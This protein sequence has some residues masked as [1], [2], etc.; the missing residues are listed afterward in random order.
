MSIKNKENPEMLGK[1]RIIALLGEGSMGVVYKAVDPDIQEY[2]AIKTIHKK[3]LEGKDRAVILQRFVNEVKAGRLLRHSNIVAIYHYE[4]VEDTCFLVMEYV[5]GTT[6][7]E[8]MQ[9]NPNLPK[10]EIC[11]IMD[12]LLDGLQ[13]AHKQGVIHRDIKPENLIL[14]DNGDVRIADFG[15]ARL[16]S[17]AM[18]TDGSILGSPAY[19]SP[20]QCRGEQVDARSDLF[21]AGVVLY[22]LLTGEKPFSGMAFMETMQQ[23]LNVDPDLPSTRI[24]TLEPKWDHV[25]NKALAKHADNRYQ[26]AT[27]F[28]QALRA[29]GDYQDIDKL[30]LKKNRWKMWLVSS[31]VMAVLVAGGFW[32][33]GLSEI[34]VKERKGSVA[35]VGLI[36]KPEPEITVSLDQQMKQLLINYE[37][38]ELFYT[39]DVKDNIISVTGFV[40]AINQN[41]LQDDLTGL[42][43][44]SNQS[45]ELK[46]SPLIDQNCTLLN[47]LKPFVQR[48]H[49]QKHGLVIEPSQHDSVFVEGERPVFEV[50][51]PD[52]PG[53]LYVDYY[54]A[55]GK[56]FHLLPNNTSQLK[57][58]ANQLIFIGK[59]GATR[60]WE[61]VKP[62][63]K[64]V[65]SVIISKLPLFES[66][67][68]EIEDS[69]VYSSAMRLALFQNK[70][71]VIIA[72]YFV[73]TT[74][75]LL[76]ATK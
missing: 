14:K 17:S 60:Q 43:S 75:S 39:T 19:M 18:T 46:L 36:L 42:I 31:L 41:A 12:E 23:I 68:D 53:F 27:D 48:N 56:V 69:G 58:N 57:T 6:L 29:I 21:S 8:Y 25:V 54:M 63:G 30:S 7:K 13:A 22:Q 26:S 1:Y 50:I 72:D 52:F 70:N 55:D 16:D 38:D 3:H 9:D 28:Q 2:V 66:F 35:D 32:W 51:T 33:S 74:I 15:V 37:C 49:S 65:M 4:E 40:S 11:R 34:I 61:I 24:P 67:R 71:T 44:I 45:L 59:K 10:K 20:E 5:E 62:F 47:I 73:I 76:D 64:E